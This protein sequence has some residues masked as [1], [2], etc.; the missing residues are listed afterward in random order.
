MQPKEKLI[1]RIQ[2]IGLLLWPA[3]TIIGGIIGG[4]D[5]SFLGGA[6]AG[7]LVGLGILIVFSF[8]IRSFENPSFLLVMLITSAIGFLIG[9]IWGLKIAVIG[10]IAGAV[11]GFLFV[12]GAIKEDE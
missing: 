6:L 7:F 3:S 12:A 1:Q 5:G 8:I 2:R 11:F 10:A 9:L 4:S